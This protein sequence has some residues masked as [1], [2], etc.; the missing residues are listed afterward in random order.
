MIPSGLFLFLDDSIVERNG[1]LKMTLNT[2]ILIPKEAPVR[3]T[4]AQLEE[5]DYRNLYR[6]FSSKGRNPVT[7][8]RVLFKVL[9]YAN[10]F[11]IYSNRQIEDA[12]RNRIDMNW[13]LDEEPAPDHCTIARFKQRCAKEI[14][15]LFY[16]YVQSAN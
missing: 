5:L 4:D 7:D 10:Q 11:H 9:A 3:L 8:P 6:A 2:E 13:L 15:D 1:Q 14:E 16:Q 12:C